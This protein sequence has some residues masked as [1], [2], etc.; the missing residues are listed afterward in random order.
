MLRQN[1][2]SFFTLLPVAL[3]AACGTSTDI[4]TAPASR[5]TSAAVAG[6]C[7][8]PPCRPGFDG[9]I[10]FTA[11]LTR[12]QQVPPL[13]VSGGVGTFSLNADSTALTFEIRVV[14]VPSVTAAHFH[15][16][17]AGANGGVV[18]DLQ[19]D[20][21]DGEW[22]SSGT[23]SADEADQPLTADLLAELVAGNFYV[24]V[25][26]EDY[27]A[28]EVRGQVLAEG[29][30]FAATLSRQQGVPARPAAAGTATFRLNR[31]Q[32]ALSYDIRVEGVPTVSAAH[33]HNAEAGVNGGV[34]RELEGAFVGDVWV[35]SG[36]WSAGELEQPLTPAL[37]AELLAGAIYVNVHT[38]DYGPGEVRGQVTR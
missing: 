1:I 31:A 10:A 21:V 24:N 36:L 20:V 16:A 2:R 28:G 14:G 37:V 3:I 33:F 22:V 18:R 35:S 30:G 13:P 23:W 9:S 25:H 34:V 12:D 27:P 8:S 38:P 11:T 15:N 4:P 26:T 17:P 6:T 29:A 32:T 5:T 7:E 19:G